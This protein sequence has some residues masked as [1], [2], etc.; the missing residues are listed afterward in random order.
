V[1]D[2]LGAGVSFKNSF[3]AVGPNPPYYARF[4]LSQNNV[5]DVLD[6]LGVPNSFK[7]TYGMTCVP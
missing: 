7:S 5:V 4:D 1:N 3:G 6:L 2:L